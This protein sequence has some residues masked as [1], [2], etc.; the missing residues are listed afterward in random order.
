MVFEEYFHSKLGKKTNFGVT[1]TGPFANW[2]RA[3]SDWERVR[4][5]APSREGKKSLKLHVC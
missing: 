1:G 4:L 3:G 5:L 2:D